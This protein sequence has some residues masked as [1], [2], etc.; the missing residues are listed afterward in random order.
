VAALRLPGRF[1]QE[2]AVAVEHR[3]MTQGRALVTAAVAGGLLYLA[4]AIA[5]GSPPDAT[6]SGAKVVAW[7]SRHAHHARVYA[8]SAAFGT[9]AFAVVAALVRELLP[10][11][12]RAVFT[13]G[14]AAF[15]VENAVQAWVWAGL[16]LHPA[17]LQPDTARLALDIAS[18]WGPLL[19]GATTT[20]IG[21]VTLL[22]LRGT[23]LIPRWLTVLGVI[24]F[25]EQAVE[26]VTVF[27]THGFIAPGGA[28]NVVLGAALSLIWLVGLVVWAAP[29]L[30][31]RA[32][33]AS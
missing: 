29:R 14:A 33:F 18:Y 24:A 6:D 1:G 7:F 22:G 11:P 23:P 30:P 13:I 21:A 25:V 16:A 20:M 26:T 12:H 32:S 5:L 9:L 27:G 4:G 17:R 3:T 15:V 10:A 19:T 8:W 31:V 28:M 2:T